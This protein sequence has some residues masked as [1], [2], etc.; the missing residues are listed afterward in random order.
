[1]SKNPA[2]L[3]RLAGW[4]RTPFRCSSVVVGVVAGATAVV[5]VVVADGAAVVV[6]VLAG[7]AAIVVVAGGPAVV[8]RGASAR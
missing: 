1:M 2:N 8:V 7:G 5:V 4:E 6:V 3:N